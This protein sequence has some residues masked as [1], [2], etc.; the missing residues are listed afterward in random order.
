MVM[1]GCYSFPSHV[2]IHHP[3]LPIGIDIPTVA[4]AVRSEF[5]QAVVT[6]TPGCTID[7]ESRDGLE[8]AAESA[9]GAD[10]AIVVL[11]D[12]AG[13]FGRGT[14]G[15]GCDAESLQLPGVQAE[16]L[17]KILDTGTP[18]IVVVISGRPYAL[19]TAPARA[20]AIVQTFFPGEEGGV[21]IARVLSG[22]VDPSGRLPVS[23]P[24]HP[25]AQ[26]STYLGAPLAQRSGVS[27]VDPT[28]A[29]GFGHGLNYT[30]FDWSGLQ[31]NGLPAD[32]TSVAT[33]AT[34]GSVAVAL[35][36]R[37]AGARTGKETVQLYLHD[38]VA[39]VTRPVMR[40]IGYAQATLAPGEAAQVSFVVPSDLSSFT[41][42]D[43]RRIVESGDLELRLAASSQDVR[44]VANVRLVGAARVVDHTRAL[45]CA[46]TVRPVA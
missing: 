23:V 18:V 17:E 36:V 19:G 4:A 1:L 32:E 9:R 45:H 34:E 46:T 29:Y 16:L 2:G 6:V 24:A 13:L 43:G 22:S 5:P 33:T 14:S 11:G 10:V 44:L 20:A 15:E 3:D 38:P 26:P 8:G 28:A 25:G 7:G 35:T 12:R 40:L 21:A 30:T 41:G 37:N 42:I 27:N 31:V 39:S